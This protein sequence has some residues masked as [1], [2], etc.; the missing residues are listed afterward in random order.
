MNAVSRR[1]TGSIAVA[2]AAALTLS[3][4]FGNPLD[5][6]K[7]NVEK[8]IEEQTGGKVAFGELPQD[9]PKAE[10]PIIDGDIAGAV[11]DP[12]TKGWVVTVVNKDSNAIANAVE[13]LKGA[14]FTEEDS[15]SDKVHMLK[16][17]KWQ[18]ML[19]G[20]ADGVMYTVTS[21]QG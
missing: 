13:K 18:V 7:K 3:G 9:F 16:S 5:G 12:A 8:Q 20:S 6:V 15:V 2:I 14:G 19:I 17:D 4:C 1:A 11:A 10:V 21:A